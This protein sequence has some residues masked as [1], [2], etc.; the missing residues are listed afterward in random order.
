[1][2]MGMNTVERKREH[3]MVS[4]KDS[5]NHFKTAG[6]QTVENCRIQYFFFFVT[7]F[8]KNST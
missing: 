7:F 1:M 8:S 3:C 6:P 4:W 5:E 2:S